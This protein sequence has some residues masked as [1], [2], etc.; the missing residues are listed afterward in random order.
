MQPLAQNQP[1]SAKQSKNGT[2][3]PLKLFVW[4][5]HREIHSP[6]KCA[7]SMT[8]VLIS[9]GA[10][11]QAGRGEEERSPCTCGAEII[12][13]PYLKTPGTDTQ[14]PC[15]LQNSNSAPSTGAK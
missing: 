6:N 14:V 9:P 4:M 5:W 2:L 8:R 11:Q 3:I 12:E 15:S 13:I 10:E 1:R 7:R